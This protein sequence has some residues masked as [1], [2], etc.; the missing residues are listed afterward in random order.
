[1]AE[2]VTENNE[3]EGKTLGTLAKEMVASEDT[4][5]AAD[6]RTVGELLVATGLSIVHIRPYEAIGHKGMTF[7]F[8]R[9]NQNVMEVSTAI[10]H[11]NDT[12][13]KRT[14]SKVAIGNFTAGKTVFLP[15]LGGRKG[16]PIL[17][18]KTLFGGGDLIA[19]FLAQK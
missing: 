14:G 8:R 9:V 11:R 1:M 17:T 19:A 5:T 7:A 16:S 6:T 18:I 15:I 12:F 13:T 4:I 10:L 3:T 2:F